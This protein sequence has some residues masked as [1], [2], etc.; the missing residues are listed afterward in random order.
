MCHSLLPL[1]RDMKIE[2]LATARKTRSAQRATSRILGPATMA[3]ALFAV[4]C[5]GMSEETRLWWSGFYA[6][7]HVGAVWGGSRIRATPFEPSVDGTQPLTVRDLQFGPGAGGLQAGW[8]GRIGG[9]WMFGVE[10]DLTFPNQMDTHR[11]IFVP[12]GIYSRVDDVQSYGS[13]R[14]RVGHAFGDWLLYGTAGVAGVRAYVSRTQQFGAALGG[15]AQAGDS[16]VARTWR[17]GWTLGG[18]VELNLSDAWSAKLEYLHTSF[19]TRGTYFPLA[20]QSIASNLRL[21]EVRLGLN[22]HFGEP[23]KDAPARGGILPNL[24]MLSIHGQTTQVLQSNFPFRARYSGPNSLFPGFQTRE[25]ISV[26]GYLGFR[27]WV[28]TEFYFNPE[29]FQGFGLSQTHGAAG[30]PNGEAQKGGSSY[31]RYSTARLFMRQSIGF[32]GEQETIDGG[33]NQFGGKSTSRG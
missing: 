7:G 32:G 9:A 10:A 20:G 1:S 25:T 19:D 11:D 6:G 15:F 5:E 29:P 3:A 2:A 8:N 28:G 4:P 22:Y 12:S 27:P 30:F 14:A 21:N 26:T 23:G 18:G 31:P 17:F 13:L 24:E 33:A 16:E